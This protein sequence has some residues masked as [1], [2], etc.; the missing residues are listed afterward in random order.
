MVEDGLSD[1]RRIAQLLSSEL[2]GLAVGPLADVTV[3]DA[4]PDVEPTPAG[5][6]AFR[7]SHEGTNVGAVS[8]TP[9]AVLVELDPTTH[10]SDGAP[11][12]VRVDDAADLAVRDRSG[13]GL[14]IRIESGAAVKPAID[15]VREVLAARPSDTDGL[16]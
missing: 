10:G 4:D 5:A 1:G 11:A 7:I 16:R 14:E 2:T 3:T 6:L 13:R 9:D 15:V 12:T 8:V